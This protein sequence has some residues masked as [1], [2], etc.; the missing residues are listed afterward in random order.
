MV[1]NVEQIKTSEKQHQREQISDIESLRP[2]L[3]PLLAYKKLYKYLTVNL[4]SMAYVN[5][6]LKSKQEEQK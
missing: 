2:L 6:T 4:L 5:A 3:S 1:Q